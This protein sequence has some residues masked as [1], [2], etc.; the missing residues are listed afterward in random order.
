MMT[1]KSPVLKKNTKIQNHKNK[2]KNLFQSRSKISFIYRA[3]AS[4]RNK[5]AAKPAQASNAK[6][7]RP[8]WT[9]RTRN[10]L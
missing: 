3:H 6:S 1:S 9:R 5:K 4:G 8:T 10:C 7:R 2:Y